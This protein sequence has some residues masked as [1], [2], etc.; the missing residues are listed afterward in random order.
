MSEDTAGERA[1]HDH[2]YCFC[3]GANEAIS[4]LLRRCGGS[5]KVR[6]HFRQSRLEFLKGVRSILD[7]RIERLGRTGNKGTRVVVE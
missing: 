4:N 5:E 6:E 3:C 7:E 2:R 1:A